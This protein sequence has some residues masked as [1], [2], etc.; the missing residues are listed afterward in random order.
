M[1]LTILF[2]LF[3]SFTPSNG[4]H[5]SQVDPTDDF[6]LLR[7]AVSDIV[8]SNNISQLY[9]VGSQKILRDNFRDLLVILKDLNEQVKFVYVNYER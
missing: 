9:V 8:S 3:I 2:V 6:S 7:R 5:L 4:V 1:Y